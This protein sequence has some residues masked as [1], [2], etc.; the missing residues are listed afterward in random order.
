MSQL[1]NAALKSVV[2]TRLFIN[3]LSHKKAK[4]EYIGKLVTYL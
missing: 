1:P 3:L 4:V 2:G